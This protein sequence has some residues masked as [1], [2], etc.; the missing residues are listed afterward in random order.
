FC[1]QTAENIEARRIG[2]CFDGIDAAFHLRIAAGEIHQD[3]FCC[4]GYARVSARWD[5]AFA[6]ILSEGEPYRDPNRFIVNSVVIE[7]VLSGIDASGHPAEES[8]HHLF[9]IIQQVAGSPLDAFYSV[10]GA[11]LLQACPSGMASSDLGTNVAFAL[12]W[13]TNV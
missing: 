2:N 3:S 13:S 10:T 9:G 1:K 6:A 12:G 8:T 5:C 4:P 7:K 11:N